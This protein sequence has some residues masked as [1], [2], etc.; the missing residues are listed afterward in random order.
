M[1]MF[2]GKISDQKKRSPRVISND[3]PPGIVEIDGVYYRET[4][5]GR[6]RLEMK[7]VGTLEE[8]LGVE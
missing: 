7:E 3:L 5:E 1:T 2:I 8:L 6:V 4:E